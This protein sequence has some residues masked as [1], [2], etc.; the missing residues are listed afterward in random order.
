M[1]LTY[2]GHSAILVES[3]DATVIFDPFLT[4]NPKAAMKAEDVKVDAVLVTHG[5]NDHVG[6]AEEIAKRN[7]ATVVGTFELATYLENKGVRTHGMQVGGAHQFDFGWVKM[8]HAQ[9]GTGFVTEQGDIVYMGDPAGMLYRVEEKTILHAGDT[10]LFGDMKLIGDRHEIDIAFLPIGD[11]YTMGPED[12]LVAVEFLNPKV[13]VPVH[14]NT[15]PL[16]EQDAQAFAEAVKKTGREC[17]P[18]SPGESFDW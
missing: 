4:G 2:L 3:T 16:I 7:D 9:H 5:H 14:Y 13:V 18:L 6:D 1:R 17:Y 15:F 12:A 10:G 8:V 11:N